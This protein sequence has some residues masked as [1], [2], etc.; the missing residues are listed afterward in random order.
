MK[1]PIRIRIGAFGP[2]RRMLSGS[3]SSSAVPSMKPEPRAMKYCKYLRSQF[4]LTITAPPRPLARAAVK[5]SRILVMIGLIG[6]EPRISE[7]FTVA[8]VHHV[9]VLHD[10]VFA[11]QAQHAFGA[12]DCFC[13]RV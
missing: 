13:K 6:D 1:Y 4:F 2:A 11:F 12:G 8:D 5:P 3:I 9:P 7:S 10:V